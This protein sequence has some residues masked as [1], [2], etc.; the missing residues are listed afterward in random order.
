MVPI[1][2]STVHDQ[3]LDQATLLSNFASNV[4]GGQAFANIWQIKIRGL[5]HLQ[6]PI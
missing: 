3:V 5:C 6:M 1:R 4:V 2:N